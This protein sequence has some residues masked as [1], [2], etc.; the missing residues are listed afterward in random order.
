[1]EELLEERGIDEAILEELERIELDT[2]A[3]DSTELLEDE[4][5][6]TELFDDELEALDAAA[7]SLTK[8]VTLCGSTITVAAPL[9][10]FV[11]PP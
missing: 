3:L 9:F 5:G 8:V 11:V 2:A 10:T 4:L 7:P 6:A 1:M